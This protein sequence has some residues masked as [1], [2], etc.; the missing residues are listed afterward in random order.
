MSFIAI[1]I[2]KNADG[3]MINCNDELEWALT[4]DKPERVIINTD[5]ITRV[6]EPEMCT[7]TYSPYRELGKYFCIYT[8]Y[9]EMFVCRENEYEGIVKFLTLYA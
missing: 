1:N 9:N 3:G 8:N 6:S 4:H 2:L 5:Y 7:E